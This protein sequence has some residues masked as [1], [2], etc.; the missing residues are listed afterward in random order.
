M[1]RQTKVNSTRTSDPSVKV[2]LA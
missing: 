2:N 1:A